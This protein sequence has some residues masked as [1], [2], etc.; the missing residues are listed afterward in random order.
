MQ[1][2][3]HAWRLHK[4]RSAVPSLWQAPFSS[5]SRRR[6]LKDMGHL[7]IKAISFCAKQH[8][9]NRNEDPSFGPHS[10]PS[11]RKR[12]ADSDTGK[13]KRTSYRSSPR[14]EANEHRAVQQARGETSES[15]SQFINTTWSCIGKVTANIIDML[16]GEGPGALGLQA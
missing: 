16:W 13:R 8:G 2:R 12:R 14:L 5:S 1:A 15:C 6:M 7:T 9:Q 10:I 4:A 11:L 3:K